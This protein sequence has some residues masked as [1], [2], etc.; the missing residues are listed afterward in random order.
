MTLKL[1]DGRGLPAHQRRK[2][3]GDSQAFLPFLDPIV[4][5]ETE[6]TESPKLSHQ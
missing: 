3:S 4:N 1:T 5:F 2:A 6:K